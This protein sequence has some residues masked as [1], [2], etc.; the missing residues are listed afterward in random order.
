[1]KELA[2]WTFEG[3]LKVYTVGAAGIRARYPVGMYYSTWKSGRLCQFEWY[4][5]NKSFI[6]VSG[7]PGTVFI[8]QERCMKRKQGL[9]LYQMPEGSKKIYRKER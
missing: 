8:L 4:R 5:D 1:M 9:V 2:E 3:S 6:T 7:F